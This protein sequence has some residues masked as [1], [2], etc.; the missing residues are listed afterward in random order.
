MQHTNPKPQFNQTIFFSPSFL[1]HLVFLHGC[2][3]QVGQLARECLCVSANRRNIWH[4]SLNNVIFVVNL[5]T[6]KDYN[7]MYSKYNYV[8]LLL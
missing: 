7:I 2:W 5:I 1:V 4:F 3:S 8:L 6:I